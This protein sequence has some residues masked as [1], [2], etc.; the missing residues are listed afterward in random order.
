MKLFLRVSK[1]TKSMFSH[2]KILLNSQR[3]NNQ[4]Y[5]SFIEP[6]SSFTSNL[7]GVHTYS[8]GLYPEEHKPSGT[9]NFSRF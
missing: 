9:V 6:Y 1:Q 5:F 7:N 2:D 8:F 3:N 4:S